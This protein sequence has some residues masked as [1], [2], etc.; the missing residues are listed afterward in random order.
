[1]GGVADDDHGGL[2]LHALTLEPQPRPEPV[3]SNET[4]GEPPPSQLP[5]GATSLAHALRA[6]E[7]AGETGYGTSECA[8]LFPRL[9][10]EISET[11]P[12]A[13]WHLLGAED[14]IRLAEL[15][16]TVTPDPEIAKEGAQQG[17]GWLRSFA[18][19][20]LA[21][22]CNPALAAVSLDAVPD[23]P[24][25]IQRAVARI[26]IRD[27]G[28]GAPSE[29]LKRHQDIL[30]ARLH[31]ARAMIAE[32]PMRSA[33]WALAS[34]VLAA[35]R[36]NGLLFSD[37]DLKPHVVAF[38]RALEA[39]LLRE[40]HALDLPKRAG[41]LARTRPRIGIVVRTIGPVP[42]TWILKG[43]LKSLPAD[44][45]DVTVFLTMQRDGTDQDL[46]TA[47][48]MSLVGYSVADTV[49]AI[50]S[51]ELDTVILG[52]AFH[53]FMRDAEI[54]AHRLAP[55]QITLA[56]AQ[57]A[58][59]GMT[60][61]D[62]MIIGALQAPAAARADCTETVVIA[63][64]TGQ[65][66]GFGPQSPAPENTR[67]RLRANL[68]IPTDQVILTSGAMED[69][70][71]PEALDA[72]VGVLAS[73][74]DAVLILYP[75]A[76][77]WYRNYDERAFASR[78]RASCASAGVDETRVVVLPPLGADG[79]RD[80]LASADVY[81]VAFPYSG[82]T[83]TLEALR[84]DLPVVARAE[85][86]QRGHQA[87]G[88]LE[89]LGLDDFVAETTKDYVR[90]ASEL[91]STPSRRDDATLRIRET[92][93]DAFEQIDSRRWLTSHL[94][95]ARNDVAEEPR[96][97]FH[98]IPKTGGTS[99]RRVLSNWF[100]V[101]PEYPEP[102]G[103]YAT[104][105]IELASLGA[106]EIAAG[107]YWAP[108][109][110]LFDRYPEFK[111]SGHW[112]LLSF[113]RDP[114]E[115]SMSEY[116]FEARVRPEHDPDFVP[117]ALDEY[118][119]TRRSGYLSQFDAT[120]ATWEDQI[121]RYWFIGTLERFEDCVTWLADALGKPVPNGLPVENV[122]PRTSE[123]SPE[124]VAIFRANNAIDYAIY[125]EVNRRLD[126]LLAGS[127]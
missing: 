25:D 16:A 64:G 68:G 97:F 62:E 95:G 40:G 125:D 53:G 58:T 94:L 32:A 102:W 45:A 107:H 127:G 108:D 114:L 41:Q 80:M 71:S 75:F 50:R 38:A 22:P 88:W 85:R 20:A 3:P 51:E 82:A 100:K 122:T 18:Q 112:R 52:A 46:G 2:A 12:A 83:T 113:V 44:R 119:S 26:L 27:P 87:A 115:K 78:V 76:A 110:A 15:A 7:K 34:A 28:P 23:L 8:G 55:R 11:A 5:G 104:P 9:A 103:T 98:H 121:G 123:A 79:V 69:K 57:Y 54:A 66:F 74:P 65:V 59:T 117:M 13:M 89:A 118:L 126:R 29:M 86:T 56:A 96:Y 37:M 99:F 109:M 106:D 73:C 6:L 14:L 35:T 42:E 19:V 60:R 91:A 21:G 1:A 30:V 4:K 48:I 63:P 49:A 70:I 120:E 31:E 67:E 92:G 24:R 81:L 90:I 93:P 116:F 105:P 61:V 84:A 17:I 124:A 36:P 33:R 101:I 111:S 10:R 72:W 43:I 47:R 77:N 39:R